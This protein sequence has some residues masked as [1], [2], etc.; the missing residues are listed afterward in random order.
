MTKGTA[1]P[2]VKKILGEATEKK[3]ELQESLSQISKI[4]RG[5]IG[6]Q[7]QQLRDRYRLALHSASN[8]HNYNHAFYGSLLE[9]AIFILVACF[10]VIFSL[11][12]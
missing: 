12:F 2:N 5:I 7:R 6:I 3:E 1:D 8:Q 9:T 11:I 4:Y 10:Q